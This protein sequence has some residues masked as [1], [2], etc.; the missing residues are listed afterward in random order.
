MINKTSILLIQNNI[1]ALSDLSAK[2]IEAG[3]SERNIFS[4]TE[5]ESAERYLEIA[6]ISYVI[7]DADLYNFVIAS[8]ISKFSEYSP[9]HVVINDAEPEQKT[10]RMINDKSLTFLNSTEELPNIL[11]GR[12][13]G[14]V[15]YPYQKTTN[16]QIL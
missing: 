16:L 8:T 2:C 12:P 7:I 9:I 15:S 10:L 6:G 14:V 11:N 1:Q 5:I 3:I 13:S 4:V